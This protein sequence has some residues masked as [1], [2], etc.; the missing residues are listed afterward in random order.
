ME[1][2]LYFLMFAGFFVGTG[3][4]LEAGISLWDLYKERR[5]KRLS[6]QEQTENQE[7]Q[8]YNTRH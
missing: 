2:P 8:S 5:Q 1:W 7:H 4:I 3:A 6:R